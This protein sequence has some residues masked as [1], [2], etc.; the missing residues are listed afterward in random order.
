MNSS[1]S[2]FQKESVEFLRPLESTHHCCISRPYK[3]LPAA[4]TNHR[5][6]D[7]RLH[8]DHGGIDQASPIQITASRPYKSLPA[9]VR[10]HTNHYQQGWGPIQIT[11]HGAA[12]EDRTEGE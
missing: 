3:S 2:E 7:Q 6:N 8:S 10:S 5:H 12:E 11:T 1:D 9:G 4:H